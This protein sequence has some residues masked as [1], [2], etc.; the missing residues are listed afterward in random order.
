MAEY[1]TKRQKIDEQSSGD[2]SRQVERSSGSEGLERASRWMQRSGN[3][4]PSVF[5]V[6]PGEFFTMSPIT[7]MRRFTEDIDRAISGLGAG[8]RRSGFEHDL[9]W[10]PSIEVRQSGNNL[11]VRTDLPGVNENDVRLEATE[12]GLAIEGER[13]RETEREEGGVYHSERVYGR[14]FRLIPLPDEAKLDQAQANFRNGVLEVTIPVSESERKRRQIPISST[15][16]SQQGGA[17]SS[18]QSSTASS[19]Q[20]STEGARSRTAS[21]SS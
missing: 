13:K 8:S 17:S 3:Y 15:G 10:V 16:Q 9:T 21:S 2:S 20:G 4:T 1:G 12:D 18:Q 14:F 11:V 5:S 7:L 19:Q 6:S